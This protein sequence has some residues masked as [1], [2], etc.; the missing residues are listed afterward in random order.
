MQEFDNPVTEDEPTK[1]STDS[2]A[3]GESRNDGENGPSGV[4]LGILGADNGFRMLLFNLATHT[5]A[6]VIP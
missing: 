6:P 3:E 2:A 4:A 5:Y 1:Q